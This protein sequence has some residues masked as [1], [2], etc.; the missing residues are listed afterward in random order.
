MPKGTLACTFLIRLVNFPVAFESDNQLDVP[1]IDARDAVLLSHTTN[2]NCSQPPCRVDRSLVNVPDAF[3]T[4]PGYASRVGP[5]LL[6]QSPREGGGGQLVQS[7]S[8]MTSHLFFLIAD[9]AVPCQTVF[10]Y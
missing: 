9:S 4:L 10:L 6:M 3:M 8:N 7:I 5:D 1:N 2:K